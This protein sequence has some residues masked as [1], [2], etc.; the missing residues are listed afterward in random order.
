MSTARPVVS[1][2]PGF[3]HSVRYAGFTVVV[4]IGGRDSSVGSGSGSGGG[5]GGSGGSSG[6]GS[7]SSDGSSIA[8]VYYTLQFRIAGK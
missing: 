7:S 8:V 1:P 3:L 5:S 4:I 2:V 6:D